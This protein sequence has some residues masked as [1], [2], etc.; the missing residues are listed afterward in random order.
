M[1]SAR[2]PSPY[3]STRQGSSS[4]I[5][6]LDEL[7]RSTE[8]WS[9]RPEAPDPAEVHEAARGLALGLAAATQ[10]RAALARRLDDDGH[11]ERSAQAQVATEHLAVAVEQL[12]RVGVLGAETHLGVESWADPPLVDR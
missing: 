9:P 2:T 8:S 11:E 10:V 5:S 1:G 3:A 12:T 7:R 6:S 4:A